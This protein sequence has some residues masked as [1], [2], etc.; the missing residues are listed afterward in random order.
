MLS[1]QVGDI[2]TVVPVPTEIEIIRAGINQ[3]MILAG[4]HALREC[5]D[6]RE[7]G[8]AVTDSDLVCAIYAAMRR[9]S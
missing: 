7:I 3:A 6:R 5:E 4:I 1:K 2:H 8:R 9:R